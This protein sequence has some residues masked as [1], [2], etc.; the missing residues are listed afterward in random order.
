M[1]GNDKDYLATRVSY[2]LNLTGPS[3]TIQT[4]CSTSLVAVHMAC[5]S[6]LAGECDL[7]LA[8]GVAIG[9]PQ[10]IGYRHEEGGY[11]SPDGHCRAFDADARGTIFGNGA[12]V[13]ALKRLQEAIADGDR[14]EAVIK[15]SAIN[16]DG[17]AKVGFTAPS[18]R[19]Q[20]EVI[21][22]ALAVSGVDPASIAYV[23]AHGTG[24]PLGDPIE[25][26]ALS[27]VF[28]SHTDRRQFCALGS[29]KTNVG[30]LD[31]AA[32]V[33]G[34]IK[35]VLCLR[36]RR[37]VPS[38]HFRQPNP[39]IDFATTPF[40]VNTQLRDWNTEPGLKRRAGVSSF[41]IGGT[42]AHVVLEEAPT[43]ETLPPPL[44]Q[45]HLLLLSA[46]SGEAL[47][48]M[49]RQW[50][51]HLRLT[52]D[53]PADIA[54]TAALRRSHHPHRLA[55]VGESADQWRQQLEH[56][57]G[58][59]AQSAPRL[60]WV[61][62]GQGPQSA[63]MGCEL[64]RHH[65]VFRH[66]A[67]QALAALAQA[68][69]QHRGLFEQPLR[70]AEQEETTLIQPALFALQWALAALWQSWGMEPEAVV[71]HSL[72]EVAAA[73]AAGI[74]RLEQGARVV[75]QRS[76][77]L[78]TRSG[79][80]AMA[81]VEWSSQELLRSLDRW[82]HE[83][84]GESLDIA[85]CNS[86]REFV[87]SGERAMV[88]AWRQQTAAAGVRCRLL[89]TSAVAGHSG[90]V[91]GLDDELEKRL[92]GLTP[93]PAQKRFLSAVEGHEL[94]G[95]E[96]GPR[97]WA[98]NLRQ[99]VC[100]AGAVE[101][102]LAAGLNAW[103]EIS[104]HPVLTPALSECAGERSILTAGSLQ[105]EMSEQLS[106]LRTVARF[107]EAGAEPH[108]NA[109]FP[110]RRPLVPLPHYPWQ[111]QRFWI[112]KPRSA[113]TRGLQRLSCSADPSIEFFEAHLSLRALP[114]IGN[115]RIDGMCVV[116]GALY[117]SLGI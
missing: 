71:G 117:L 80:G 97:Y 29:V 82:R 104:P 83:P 42:N 85:A 102:G 70:P 31:S 95:E 18:A 112:D 25:V 56:A 39:A 21:A 107:W 22:Q 106:L 6:L 5:Q 94:P 17:A 28:A 33:A 57:R 26:A 24:T 50:Q 116:P 13:V 9:V 49:R 76:L 89:R 46:R 81:A 8:G 77:L 67:E 1:I 110:Q 27:R 60:C 99:T 4:A 20:A 91:A 12:G 38:L 111:R 65:K 92:A 61:F 103:L 7:A 59:A 55:V 40:Y 96:L 101:A 11:F 64:W 84:G 79:L 86:P 58:R 30:H 93:A 47:D 15:G 115:H 51:Q 23:E 53:P 72:G 41:G 14:I 100:F 114:A 87:V 62:A 2:R 34:L 19:G 88:E 52:D 45:P 105:R 73:C 78:A 68:G 109:L 66:A 43:P 113:R 90:L 32:G 35:T 44:P 3:V 10:R 98:R 63:A 36:H 48:A 16:N 75:V 74:L 54:W 37:L 69:W 108:W